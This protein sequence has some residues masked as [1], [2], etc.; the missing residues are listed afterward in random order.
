M[1]KEQLISRL[2]DLDEQAKAHA[3]EYLR[4][5]QAPGNAAKASLNDRKGLRL[6]SRM[7]DLMKQIA[8]GA[9][10]QR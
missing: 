6:R 8:E 3:S 2:I 4:L 9:F 5:I 10:L 1:H 7:K